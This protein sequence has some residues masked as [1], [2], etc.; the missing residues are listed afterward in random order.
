MTKI[1]N[2]AKFVG[3]Y[4]VKGHSK[5]VKEGEQIEFILSQRKEATLKKPKD[6]LL[7]R[8]GKSRPQYFSSLYTNDTGQKWVEFGGIHYTIE[9]KSNQVCISYMNTDAD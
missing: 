4:K 3:C 9:M 2:T 7:Y 8:L 5:W 6:F 1:S